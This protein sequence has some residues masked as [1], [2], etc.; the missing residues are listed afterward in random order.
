MII[1]KE[2]PSEGEG[3]NSEGSG[4]LGGKSFFRKSPRRV[5]YPPVNKIIMN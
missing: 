5:P 1:M 2:N 4:D 3:E